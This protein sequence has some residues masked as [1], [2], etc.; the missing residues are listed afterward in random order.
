MATFASL[1]KSK[2][3]FKKKGFEDSKSIFDSIQ[4]NSALFQKFLSYIDFYNEY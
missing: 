4:F 1:V 2:E 3:I